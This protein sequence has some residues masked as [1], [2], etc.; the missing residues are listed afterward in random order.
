MYDARESVDSRAE[1]S[2]VWWLYL[3]LGVGILLI[4]LAQ[5]APQF[6][7][8]WLDNERSPIELM[9]T[10]IPAAA[11]VVAIRSLRL[12]ALSALPL[13]RV[14]ICIAAVGCFY[15]AGEEMSWGQHLAG[16]AAPEYWATINDQKETNLHN[17]SSWFDQKPRM[18]LQIGVIVGG[19]IIPVYARFRPEIRA[20]R[21]SIIL[22]PGLC[23]PTAFMAELAD[24]T[25]DLIE[26]LEIP[27]VLFYRASEVQE[28]FFYWFILLYR[29][30]PA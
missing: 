3:P 29:K 21:W 19:L 8:T 13:L 30:R 9:H 16:W 20:H 27:W 7:S 17:V 2:P 15:I 22:P 1:L 4:A 6:Y 28:T 23:F 5:L 26:Y 14:W 12:P 25:E 11:L 24:G 18:L 10:L